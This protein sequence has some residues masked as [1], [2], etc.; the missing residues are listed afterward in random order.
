MGGFECATHRRRDRRRVDVV[1][2]TQHDRHAAA[3][4]A[5]LARAGVRTVRDGLR[6]HLIEEV[7]G[8]YEWASFLPQLEAAIGTRT[9][10]IWDLC[11][12]GMP[13]HVNLFSKEFPTQFARFAQAAAL[14]VRDRRERHGATSPAFYCPINE[15]SFWSWVGGDEAAFDPFQENMGP[16][17]KRQLAAASVLAMRAIRQV[18]P[19]AR[20]VQAEP[21]IH[22][23]AEDE[24]DV[25][26]AA[27][28]TASQYEAWDMLAGRRDAELGGSEDMLD[29]IG[30]NFYW[31][32]QWI[33]EGDRTP[34]G[35]GQHRP[36][37]RMLFEIWQRYGRPI[38]VT[39]T[40]AEEGADLGWLGYIAAEVRQALRMGVQVEGICLYPVM[41]Y[42]GWDDGRHCPCGLIEASPDWTERRLRAELTE[43]LLLQEQLFRQPQEAIPV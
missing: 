23:S 11:H 24:A 27:M 18:D 31:N 39:E 36:L 43:E 13:T 21:I 32:N 8:V 6:W 9:Q 35:H 20:F 25:D 37:H 14:L 30:V 41:D 15:I 29:V 4:Y 10:V 26:R 3:D 1:A 19:R 12:W 5:M 38:V 2:T 17:M 42:P 33:H 22:I 28:H 34:P 7:A 16:A 40:G